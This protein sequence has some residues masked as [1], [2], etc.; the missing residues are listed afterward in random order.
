MDFLWI[1][2][3]LGYTICVTQSLI[4]LTS[5][6]PM[7]PRVALAS[8][9]VAFGSQTVWLLLRGLQTGRFPVAGT[10]E[11]CAFLSWGLVI[12]YL[13]AARWYRADALKAFIFPIILVLSTV[14]AIAPVTPVTTLGIESPFQSILFPVHAGLILLAYCAFFI[15]FG[16]GLMY[17]IQERELRHK[18]LGRVFYRLPSLETCDAISFRTTAIGFVLL[19]LGIAAGII[20]LHAQDPE[21]R[22]FKGEP[23]EIFAVFSWLVYLFM[24]QSRINAR[25][26]GR[27]AAL[28]SVISFMLV[29][30]SLV[31]LRY[32]G[33]LHT[34][35]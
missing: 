7:L 33:T 6:R 17:M 3:L 24:I 26:G 4:S 11:M 2:I 12:S 14:A 9:M 1:L 15:A 13:I 8:L 29:V 20:W 22:Y 28:A 10:Q 32:F 19:T 31:G 5:S 18:R 35:G 30:C 25:W 27:T 16:A 21:G 23:D 34:F